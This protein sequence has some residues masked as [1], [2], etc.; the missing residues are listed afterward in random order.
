[1]GIVPFVALSMFAFKN[2]SRKAYRRTKTNVGI[3]NAFLSENLS[4][5]KVTQ[6]FNQEEKK[7]LSLII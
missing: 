2:L 3:L 6:I 5:M 4:G 7:K 1:M